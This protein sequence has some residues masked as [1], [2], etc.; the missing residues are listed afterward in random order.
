MPSPFSA[1]FSRRQVVLALAA[2]VVLAAAVLAG[3]HFFTL[4]QVKSAVHQAVLECAKI[5]PLLFVLAFTF[6]PYVGVPSSF[7]LLLAAGAY[8]T[9]PALVWVALGQLCNISFGYLI[10]QWFRRPISAW[11]ERRGRRLPDFPAHEFWRLIVL[12]RILPGP[13]LVVQNLLLAV[14]NVPFLL[15]IVLSLPLQFL[16][17]T[18]IILTGG[19]LFHGQKGL[20]IVGLCLIIAL[21]LLAHIVKTMYENRRRASASA[22]VGADSHA[23]APRP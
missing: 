9:G 16:M 12:I 7:L 1:R 2:V 6:L 10:G 21:A 4:A 13:P 14:A 20:L 8:G 18:G 15:Y 19:A 3:L 22:P 23:A 5:N 17:A 11:L